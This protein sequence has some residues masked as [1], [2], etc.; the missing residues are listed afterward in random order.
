MLYGLKTALSTIQ[1][2]LPQIP[3]RTLIKCP[4]C[5]G[6]MLAD[7]KRYTCYS[8]CRSGNIV[9][10]I[11]EKNHTSH[12]K[13]ELRARKDKP[14]KREQ[15]EIY[16]CNKLAMLY[17]KSRLCDCDYF[18]KRKVSEQVVSAFH[19]GYAPQESAD[20]I[21]Y[22][23]KHNVSDETIAESHLCCQ[24]S[25]NPIFW[26]RAIF[27]IIDEFGRIVG[28]G[29]RKLNDDNP[30][31]PKYLNSAESSVFSKKNTLY[32]LGNALGNDTVYL[33]EGYMDVLALYGAGIT[34]AVAAL[35]TAV[36]VNHCTLLRD[37][38]IKKVMLCMDSDGAGIKS[39]MRA[40]PILR[41]YF[42]VK[43]VALEGAKDPDEYLSA[44]GREAFERL[45]KVNGD[46]FFVEHCSEDEKYSRAL[47]F[48]L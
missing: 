20:L 11:A 9:D 16:R 29:G 38:G 2:P 18:D 24:D 12:K 30:K 25:Q 35:G 43:V 17:Y 48:L 19:L 21:A 10:F 36:G 31:S 34:N 27:P 32:G 28:F 6:Y 23:K 15:A 47:D 39:A 13:A 41:N 22:L 7:D 4:F 42:E 45:E 5:G 8:C 14:D 44:N 1:N 37:K 46:S 40:I 26:N 3:E 33:V